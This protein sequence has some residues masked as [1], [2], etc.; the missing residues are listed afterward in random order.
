MVSEH[1]L[2]IIVGQPENER[3]EKTAFLTKLDKFGEAVCAFGNDLM[4]RGLPGYFII[5]VHDDGTR[6]GYRWT[7]RDSQSLLEFRGDG[8]IV[9]P[10]SI[11]TMVFRHDE[12]DILVAEVLPSLSPPVRYNGRV[13][14]RLGARKSQATQE[15]E[16]RL[17]EKRSFLSPLFDGMPCHNGSLE[18]LDLDTFKLVY[19]PKAVD[20]EV[21]AANHREPLEQLASLKFYDLKY[22]VPTNAGLIVLGFRPTFRLPGA[23]IQYVRFDGLDVTAPFSAEKRFA[24][25]M[26]TVMKGLKEF[27]QYVVIKEVHVELG[28]PIQ[29]NYPA[30]AIEE[31]L[32]NAVIHR[33][34]QSNAPIKFYEF[35]DRIEISNPGGLF[36]NASVDNFPNVSDYRNP[37][38]AE[39]ARTLGFVNKFNVG[40]KRAMETLRTNGNPAPRFETAMPHQFMVVVFAKQLPVKTR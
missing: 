28:V 12:G 11:S 17:S 3:I 20:A 38:I 29:K 14:V 21:L 40:V 7:E 36:G 5:G 33:D 15:E 22:N 13:W 23:Y 4:N 37:S 2:E 24:G 8:R 19:L 31:L 9:P 30:A 34:Y 10:P 35:D 16:R 18:D 39:A 27:V 6:S 32:F 25:D 26:N 1:E